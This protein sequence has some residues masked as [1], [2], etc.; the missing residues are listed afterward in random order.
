MSL[1]LVTFIIIIIIAI[2]H[3]SMKVQLCMI[4][5]GL[6]LENVSQTFLL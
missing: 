6:S 3:I 4:S 5:Q 1:V 2:E